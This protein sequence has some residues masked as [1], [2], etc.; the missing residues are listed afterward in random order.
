MIITPWD[1]NTIPF[2]AGMIAEIRLKKFYQR[3]AK[4][5]LSKLLCVCALLSPWR[6]NGHGHRVR[7]IWRVHLSLLYGALSMTAISNR[8][9]YVG[10]C[11]LLSPH[12]SK[13]RE[14]VGRQGVLFF[15]L[16]FKSESTWGVYKTWA[17]PW[18]G[19][20]PTLWP[21]SWSTPWPTPNF[22]IYQ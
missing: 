18:L 4:T 2:E 17:R 5:P 3:E 15:F 9:P 13:W 12:S 16:I 20:W 11:R 22:V 8:W 1:P 21:T 10:H 14:L 19:P 7:Q 6:H